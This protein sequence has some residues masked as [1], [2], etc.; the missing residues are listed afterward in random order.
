MRSDQH[1]GLTIKAEQFLQ[2]NCSLVQ[3]PC[4][5]CGQPYLQRD[6][7]DYS[8]YKGMFGD[9]YPLQEYTLKDGTKVKEIVQADPWSSGPI[10][11]LC[12]EDQKGE[13]LFEWPQEAIDRA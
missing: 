2:D 4:P 1:A 13:H 5:T 11:F 12:L 10:F 7:Q 8:S 6:K 3:K 9:E